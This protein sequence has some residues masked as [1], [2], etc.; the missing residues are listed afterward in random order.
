M[1]FK[2]AD[3]KDIP[4][5]KEM[6]KEIFND[7]DGYIELFFEY[8][9]KPEYTFI[10]KDN[11]KIAGAVYSVYSPLVL[12]D[13]II[14]P[15]LYMCGICTKPEY[16]GNGIAGTLIENCVSFAE[17]NWVELCYL[18]PANLKLFDFYAKFGFEKATYINKTELET[19]K[20]DLPEHKQGFSVELIKLY[21]KLVY[22]FKPER[23]LK[24]FRY[25]CE[26]YSDVLLFDEGYM[27]LD[28]DDDTVYLMEQSFCGEEY[29]RIFAGNKNKRLVVYQP[30]TESGT[31][32]A[33]VKKLNRELDLPRCGYINLMLN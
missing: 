12:S 3:E 27:V 4:E 2:I 15:A 9:M 23:T 19:K 24:E 28:E 11:G 26:C 16:R 25:I 6:W 22:P 14:I 7:D 1:E 30:E 17:D 8:K 20:G 33:V 5:L 21:E 18:I 13:G 10:A 32:F 31:P 29:A